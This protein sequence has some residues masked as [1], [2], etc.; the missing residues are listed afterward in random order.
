MKKKRVGEV[1]S[2]QLEDVTMIFGA[3]TGHVRSHPSAC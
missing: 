2:E 1:Y 3:L